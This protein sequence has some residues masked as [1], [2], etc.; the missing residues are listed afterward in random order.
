MKEHVEDNNALRER[1]DIS[2]QLISKRN[3]ADQLTG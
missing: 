2:Y 1:G 3:I